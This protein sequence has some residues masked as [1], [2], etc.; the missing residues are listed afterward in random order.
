MSPGTAWGN[1]G[2]DVNEH[3]EG[4]D[5]KENVRGLHNVVQGQARRASSDVDAP[6]RTSALRNDSAT[7]QPRTVKA[8][9]TASPD[10]EEDE[11]EDGAR[12]HVASRSMRT[13]PCAWC[14][15]YSTAAE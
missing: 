5:E 7:T 2:R 14:A 10:D 11:E 13:N 12:R 3:S 8:R 15:G 1:E 4:E 6:G 9:P